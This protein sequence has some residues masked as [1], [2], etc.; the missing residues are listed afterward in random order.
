MRQQVNLY[1]PILRREKKVFSASAVVI[2]LGL[3]AFGLALTT[4]LMFWGQQ[5][6]EAELQALERQKRSAEAQVARLEARYEPPVRSETLERQVRQL[7]AELSA[8][9]QFLARFDPDA[10]SFGE[11][12]APWLEGLSRQIFDGIWLESFSLHGAGQVNL[13]GGALEPEY[14][15]RL[16]E[17]LGNEP[18]FQGKDFRQLRVSRAEERPQQVEFRLTSRAAGPTGWRTA[19]VP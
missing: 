12:F 4:G 18:V 10:V 13:G 17:R 16:V 11:G 3:V 9:E 8:K 14:V 19:L 5:R 1:Q 6:Q 7:R 15:P 2:T